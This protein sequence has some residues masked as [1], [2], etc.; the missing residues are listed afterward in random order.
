MLAHCSTKTHEKNTGTRIPV[1]LL[2]LLTDERGAGA[3]RLDPRRVQQTNSLLVGCWPQLDKKVLIRSS[4][5]VA[6]AKL[7]PDALEFVPT[8]EVQ[9][10]ALRGELDGSPEAYEEDLDLGRYRYH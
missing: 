10:Q 6:Q 5:F 7:R 4:T 9:L 1:P 3:R 2:H 8:L